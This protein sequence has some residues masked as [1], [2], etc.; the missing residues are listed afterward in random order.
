M[1]SADTHEV[2][3]KTLDIIPLVMTVMAS[4]MR[5]TGT[6]MLAPSHMR[7]LGML[8]ER[9]YRLTELAEMQAVSAPTMSNTITAL[10]ERGWVKRVRSESDRR[11]VMVEISRAG[12]E[13]MDEMY[14]HTRS[15]IAEFLSVLS[16]H[17]LELLRDGLTILNNTFITALKHMRHGP[18]ANTD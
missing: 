7:L 1:M 8:S 4:E 6:D 3:Q 14:R 11:V 13:V 5:S 12:R 15:R 10:E 2:A 16:P 18:P 17:E 9:P